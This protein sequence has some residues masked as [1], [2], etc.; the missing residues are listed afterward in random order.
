MKSWPVL[1]EISIHP[2]AGTALQHLERNSNG[3]I[4]FTAGGASTHKK[5]RDIFTMRPD[6]ILIPKK[7]EIPVEGVPS[8]PAWSPG[9]TQIAFGLRQGKDLWNLWVLDL[10]SSSATQVTFFGAGEGAVLWPAWSPDGNH[11]AFD[12]GT[13]KDPWTTRSIY[14]V[15][16]DGTD[17]QP[18]LPISSGGD[19]NHPSWS[20]DGS[21]IAFAR[22]RP[23]WMG[24]PLSQIF[25]MDPDGTD[26]QFLTNGM[27]PSWSPDGKSIAFELWSEPIGANP[28]PMNIHSIALDSK[29][30]TQLTDSAKDELE[31]TWSPDGER[32]L[33]VR[34]RQADPEVQDSD[35]YVM[36][37]DGSDPV[38]LTSE[39]TQRFWAPDWQRRP[40]PRST[41]RISFRHELTMVVVDVDPEPEPG[42]TFTTRVEIRAAPEGVRRDQGKT[43][44]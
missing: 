39:K 34:M 23:Q 6:G 17:D 1:S 9:G 43:G 2:S 5:A 16:A 14:V 27:G 18:L 8:H 25:T 42:W 21:R 12:H 26:S 28:F 33:F 22:F 15:R 38:P 31:P 36:N 24:P 40:G 19:S 3:L 32:I 30:S 35:I 7:L 10:E 29:E 44:R 11:I 13:Q 4:A 20:P 37:S 41:P